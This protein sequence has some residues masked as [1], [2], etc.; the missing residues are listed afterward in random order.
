M[1]DCIF[2][3]LFNDV[4]VLLGYPTFG[5]GDGT[6]SNGDPMGFLSGYTG[7]MGHG[8]YGMDGMF[9]GGG[10]TF[11]ATG[12]GFGTFGGPTAAAGY[13]YFHGE[14]RYYYKI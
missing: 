10:G 11:S 4:V 14:Y 2:R 12:G 13:N 1:C 6:W 7:E 8:S 9:G 3:I 5:V